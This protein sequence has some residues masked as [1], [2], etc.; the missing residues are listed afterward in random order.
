MLRLSDEIKIKDINNRYVKLC[1][2]VMWLI[3]RNHETVLCNPISNSELDIIYERNYMLTFAYLM[4]QKSGEIK[5]T[6]EFLSQKLVNGEVNKYIF[7]NPNDEAYE[8]R[9]NLKPGRE[10]FCPDFLIHSSHDN[11]GEDYEGQYMIMEAKTTSKLKQEDFDWDLFK[12]NLYVEKLNFDTAI[13]LIINTPH[14]EIAT[15]VSNYNHWHSKKLDPTEQ[16]VHNN[17]VPHIFF[18]IQ[19]NVKGQPKIYELLV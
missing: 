13:F 9:N 16:N 17:V 19:E 11:S 4:G 2:N 15:M 8:S 7:L 18:L 12:L 3:K 10:Y 6:Y 5:S 1:R 14:T